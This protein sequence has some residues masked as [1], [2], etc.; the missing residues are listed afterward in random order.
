MTSAVTRHSSLVIAG[1]ASLTPLAAQASTSAL[2]ISSG[3]TM[4]VTCLNGTCKATAPDASLSVGE[5]QTLLANGNVTVTTGSASDDI[6]VTAAVAW[7]AGSTLALDARHSIVIDAPVVDN[8]PGALSLETNDG[9]SGGFLSF[10]AKGNVTFASVSNSLTIDG[11]KYELVDSV[12]SLASA[13]RKNPNGFYALAKSYDAKKDGAYSSSPVSLFFFGTFEG[14]GNTISNLSI[15]DT[16][17][18]DSVALF[19][20]S[21][22]T[23]ADFSLIDVKIIGPFGATYLSPP[24]D[25][26][27]VAAVT[28][29][30]MRGV[31]VSGEISAGD[32]T[33]IGGIVGVNDAAMTNCRSTADV[34]GGN[35]SYVAGLAGSNNGGAIADS[36][37]TGS[38]SGGNVSYTGGVA[39]YNYGPLIRTHATGPVSGGNSAAVGGL[40]GTSGFVSDIH[41]SFATG[42][43]TGGTSANVG[44]LV[45][46]N[47]GGI[48]TS[49]ATGT[50]SALNTAKVG[51]LVGFNG[52]TIGNAYATGGVSAGNL[53]YAGGLV[54]FD[55]FGTSGVV[56]TSY[57]TGS[58]KAGSGAFVGGMLG[59]DSISFRALTDTYW[60]TTTSGITDPSKGA[61]NKKNDPGIEGLTT[62]QLRSGVPDGFSSAVW[63]EKSSINSGL[64]YLPANPPRDSSLSGIAAA[65]PSFAAR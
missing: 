9:G 19:A 60:D 14:L 22:G 41:D 13:E 28:N 56:E 24:S 48:G 62:A 35:N 21:A 26:G 15:T 46:T 40:A 27:G 33:A 63:A 20:F 34:K 57:S 11:K 32:F 39:G 53:S 29:F 16:F 8:G 44:G 3:A 43:V 25:V 58:I 64:P 23:I 52:G 51:G 2:L 54:G 18:G 42:P 5:L 49:F 12:A 59:F 47:G 6:K 7:S 17:P 61:G 50:A 65:Q 55:E 45:G 37:A 31:F 30:N 36:F 4:N 1:I 10:G 38:V